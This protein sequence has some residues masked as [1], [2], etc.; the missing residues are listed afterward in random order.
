LEWNAS[1]LSGFLG[2]SRKQQDE[3]ALNFFLG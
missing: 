3:S 2:F 1:E